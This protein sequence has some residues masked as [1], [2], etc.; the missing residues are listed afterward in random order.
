MNN[1]LPTYFLLILIMY[2][3]YTTKR[4]DCDFSNVNILQSNNCFFSVDDFDD[5]YI[6]WVILSLLGSMDYLGYFCLILDIQ[7]L[8]HFD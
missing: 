1:I 7:F 6:L 5:Q 8:F 4:Y 2:I 3:V